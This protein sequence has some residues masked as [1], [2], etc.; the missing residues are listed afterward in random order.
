VELCQKRGVDVAT[1][2]KAMNINKGTISVWKK[3]AADG[4][5]VIPSTKIAKKLAEYFEMPVEYFLYSDYPLDSEHEKK[6]TPDEGGERNY[7]DSVLMD[8]F[9]QADESTQE[10]I[11]L[12]LKLK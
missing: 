3:C 4:E 10:A 12:L 2:Y 8:A 1:A 9:K 7:G 6:P 11:L 5:P